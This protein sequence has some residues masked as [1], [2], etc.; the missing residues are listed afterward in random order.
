MSERQQRAFE[1]V[2]RHDGLTND[3]LSDLMGLP[4]QSVCPVANS[5]FRAGK[6]IDSGE[7]RPTRTGAMARVWRATE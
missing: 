7:R 5:L 6:I 1:L 3:E 2:Q 4:I